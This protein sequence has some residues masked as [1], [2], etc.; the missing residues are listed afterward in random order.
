MGS[1][2][3]TCNCGGIGKDHADDCPCKGYHPSF[4][5]KRLIKCMNLRKYGKDA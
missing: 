3:I 1:Y 4:W 5:R 2:R